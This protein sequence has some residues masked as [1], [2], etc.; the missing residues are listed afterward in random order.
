VD[1]VVRCELDAAIQMKGE[2]QL[3]SI[4]A[5]NETDLR[6]QDWRKKIETQRGAILAF[7]TKNNKNKVAKWTSAALLAGADMLKLG[8]VSRLSAR[9]S[10][11][12]VILGTQVTKPKEFAAQI[13]L[14][15]DHC[16]GVVR[17]IVDMLLAQPEGRYL[18]VK[19][20][21]KDLLRLYLVP[22]T[23]FSANAGDYAD[24]DEEEQA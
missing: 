22:A 15:M 16:W 9:D 11:T 17:A 18:L 7:E 12:H 5:L 14:S 2:D 19:D 4:K 6:T 20:P 23:A 8:Y 3:M 21:N 10:T 1:I 24:E 13:N